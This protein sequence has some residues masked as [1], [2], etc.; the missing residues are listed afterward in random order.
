VLQK[1]HAKKG[2]QYFESYVIISPVA[3]NL[4]NAGD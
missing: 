1:C 4:A 3:T 2:L